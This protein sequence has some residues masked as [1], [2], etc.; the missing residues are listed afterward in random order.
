MAGIG[1]LVESFDDLLELGG[2]TVG[3]IGVALA[4]LFNEGEMFFN[5]PSTE[6]GG[7]AGLGDVQAFATAHENLFEVG[8]VAQ[9][10]FWAMIGFSAN[11]L[12]VFALEDELLK[13]DLF[14]GE[15]GAHVVDGTAGGQHAGVFFFPFA[16]IAAHGAGT[17]LE[18]E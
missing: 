7:K 5:E 8:G 14:V 13:D 6:L 2:F 1:A 18:Q 12:D 10:G 17:E 9:D 16:P 11:S 3:E 15:G 4:I